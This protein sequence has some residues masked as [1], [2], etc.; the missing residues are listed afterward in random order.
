MARPRQVSDE[1]IYEAV[2]EAVQEHGPQVSTTE[3]AARAGL[4]QAALFKRFGNKETLMVRGLTPPPSPAL[5]KMMSDGP[6]PARPLAEQLVE[7]ARALQQRMRETMPRL[8]ALRAAGYTP[9]QIFQH[10]DV[11][12]PVLAIRAVER[13]VEVGKGHG[14]VAD[15]VN[16][17][18]FASALLGSV[19]FHSH[20]ESVAGEW[21]GSADPEAHI[22]EVVSMLCAGIEVS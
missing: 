2:R 3:I 15:G 8:T 1:E 11:P 18:A 5:F 19:F 6:D 21:L 17:R 14:M 20:M 12:P 16:G 9:E 22:A 7:L 13:W 10:F 4:S